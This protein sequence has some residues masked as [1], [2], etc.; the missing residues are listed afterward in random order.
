VLGEHTVLRGKR[1][2]FGALLL[3]AYE[4]NRL[5]CGGR[6]GTGV[7]QGVLETVLARV[8]TPRTTETPFAACTGGKPRWPPKF[9]VRSRPI[10]VICDM[11]YSLACAKIRRGDRSAASRRYRQSIKTLDGRRNLVCD[12]G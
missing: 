2:R 1:D 12:R 11:P 5:L 10:P 7:D 4:A 8:T 9:S 3:G 6:A